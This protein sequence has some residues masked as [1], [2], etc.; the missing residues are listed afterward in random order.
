MKAGL[1]KEPGL[2]EDLFKYMEKG[3]E[4]PEVFDEDLPVD[5]LHE[6]IK[7]L[8]MKMTA[9]HAQDRPSAADVVSILKKLNTE[10]NLMPSEI[11]RGPALRLLYALS[12]TSRVV[13]DE[14][15]AAPDVKDW[16]ND[17]VEIKDLDN[18]RMFLAP[19]SG[20]A[21]SRPRPTAAGPAGGCRP[22]P[23]GSARRGATSPKPTCA[24]RGVMSCPRAA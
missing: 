18:S 17:Q 20:S 13:I 3:G 16:I 10:V 11:E 15:I 9:Y 24:T 22:R 6:Y 21:R 1:G 23:S 4:R 14:H 7:D 8:I 12:D 19:S 5:V 2:G